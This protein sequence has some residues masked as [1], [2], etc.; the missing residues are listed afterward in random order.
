MTNKERL[1]K[2][3]AM[4][5]FA[6]IELHLFL[7]T[8]PNDTDIANRLDEYRIRL[9]NLTRNYVAKYGPLSANDRNAKGWDW[10]A[11]P[12]PWDNINMEGK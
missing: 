9:D 1:L 2:E 5:N 6:T 7:D 11:N 12:W 10:I 8:H 4:L 3:I